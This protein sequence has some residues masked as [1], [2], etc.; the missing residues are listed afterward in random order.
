MVH[1][2]YLSRAFPCPFT[3]HQAPVSGIIAYR[4]VFGY[5]NQV[6]VHTYLINHHHHHHYYY[7]PC[8]PL[9]D[10]GLLHL[11]PYMSF[12]CLGLPPNSSSRND[13]I[14]PSCVW[15]SPW[16]YEVRPRAPLQYICCLSIGC[17]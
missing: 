10:E 1:L 11:F 17:P 9:L 7:Q 5:L 4:Y 6:Q 8:V 2:P 12:L 15:P 3:C 14:S 13:L 16:S